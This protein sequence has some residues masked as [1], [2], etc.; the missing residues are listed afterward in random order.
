M[1]SLNQFIKEEQYIDI[2][3]INEGWLGTLIGK[4]FGAP[5]KVKQIVKNY[6]GQE[7]AAFKEVFASLRDSKM[8]K[9][10]ETLQK[11]QKAKD[12][13][14]E[15]LKTYMGDIETFSK[16]DETKNTS[17]Y[18]SF[19]IMANKLAIDL[20]DNESI[21]KLKQ[22]A[23]NVDDKTKKKIKEI[24]KNIEISTSNNSDNNSNDKSSDKNTTG[25]EELDNQIEDTA[26]EV[27]NDTPEV[28]SELINKILI[29]LI[30]ESLID[31]NIL[32]ENK[33]NKS[34]KLKNKIK[35]DEKCRKSL[36]EIVANILSFSKLLNINP[37][38]LI[39]YLNSN[40]DTF[41][42]ANA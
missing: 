33:S 40:K 16:D 20:K 21:E 32:F 3:F 14:K 18:A 37:K 10:R 2:D 7:K 41:N 29:K 12:N 25:D 28:N 5:E 1:K 11:I 36:T 31:E 13:K 26:K 4:I 23:A 42:I 38:K 34:S 30:G 27:A 9:A 24:L 19:L 15:Q 39:E 35:D 6:N 22:Y 8:N 17:E